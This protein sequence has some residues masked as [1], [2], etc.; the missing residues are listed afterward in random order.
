MN[1]INQWCK[2]SGLKNSQ[3]KN[4]VMFTNR[5]N[6]YFSK[7]LE[8]DDT[9]IEMQNSAKCIDIT[10]HSKLTWNEQIENVCKKTKGIWKQR[11]SGWPHLGP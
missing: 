3:L 7:P 6:L 5:R 4:T 11:K 9:E 1:S 10:L 8:V 2:G